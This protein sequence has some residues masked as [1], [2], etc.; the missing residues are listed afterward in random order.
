VETS[1]LLR[2]AIDKKFLATSSALEGY[3]YSTTEIVAS[4]VEFEFVESFSKNPSISELVFYRMMSTLI[5]NVVKVN[6]SRHI[7]VKNQDVISKY[8][9][10]FDKKILDIYNEFVYDLRTVMPHFV[11]NLIGGKVADYFDCKTAEESTGD[12]DIWLGPDVFSS[13]I[14]RAMLKL[15][16]KYTFI[17]ETSRFY[18][19]EVSSTKVIFQIVKESFDSFETILNGFDFLHCSVGYD[20]QDFFWKKGALKSIKK[21]EMFVNRIAPTRVLNE[22]LQK[23]IMRGYKLSFPTLSLL[24]ISSILGL[25]SV[26]IQE[27]LFFKYLSQDVEG[28]DLL[29]GANGGYSDPAI[30]NF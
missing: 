10:Q 22:R 20:G 12:Y 4:D 1:S 14:Q 9:P 21:K 2:P 15:K 19:Y 17:Q 30:D 28:F 11:C 16:H 3:D 18:E 7:F 8:Y 29:R 23:Y 24:S 27:T 26:E 25:M 13:D 6:E 5:K